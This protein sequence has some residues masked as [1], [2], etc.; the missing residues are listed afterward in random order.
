MVPTTTTALATARITDLHREAHQAHQAR[1]ARRARDRVAVRARRAASRLLLQQTEVAASVNP[2][3][4][5]CAF[6]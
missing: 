4:P 6:S 1:L 5:G 3:G 2:F